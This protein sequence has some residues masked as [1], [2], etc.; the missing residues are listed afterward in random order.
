MAIVFHV[1]GDEDSQQE[2]LLENT[3]GALFANSSRPVFTTSSIVGLIIFFF[4]S[5]Q[6]LS[7]VSVVRSETGSW[8]MAGL[9]LL[10]Y[11]GMGYLFSSLPVQFLRLL[12]TS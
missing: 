7:T 9:Q 6:C 3:S 11:T 1:A 10:F 5:L 4:I 2:R 12:G 8:R